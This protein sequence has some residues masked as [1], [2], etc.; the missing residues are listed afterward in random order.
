MI[1]KAPDSCHI[2][3]E[4]QYQLIINKFDLLYI[5]VDNN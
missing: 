3:I 5:T 2:E 1:Y 4:K